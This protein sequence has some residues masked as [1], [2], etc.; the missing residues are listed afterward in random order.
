[1]LRPSEKCKKPIGAKAF[2]E[3]LEPIKKTP[4]PNTYNLFT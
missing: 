2:F 4:N 1:M 3:F